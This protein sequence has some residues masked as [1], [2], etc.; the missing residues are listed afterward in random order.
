MFT[1]T[2]V[3]QK[4]SAYATYDSLSFIIGLR[5]ALDARGPYR[6][7]GGQQRH[8]LQSRSQIALVVGGL[9]YDRS[10]REWRFGG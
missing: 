7:R 8:F 9:W 4:L 6:S 1:T 2:F 10:Q 3:A 5:V